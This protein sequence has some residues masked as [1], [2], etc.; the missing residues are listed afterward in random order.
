MYVC[1]V[2]LQ[3][4][5]TVTCPALA[6]TAQFIPFANTHRKCLPGTAIVKTM[7]TERVVFQALVGWWAKRRVIVDIVWMFVVECSERTVAG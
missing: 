4:V 6:Q 1:E 7:R 5:L 3:L 2:V